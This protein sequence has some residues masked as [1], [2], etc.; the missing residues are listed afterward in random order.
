MFGKKARLQRY[1]GEQTQSGRREPFEDLKEGRTGWEGNV[2][3]IE[4]ATLLKG[5]ILK[6]L[7]HTGPFDMLTSEENIVLC[8]CVWGG[9]LI[10]SFKHSKG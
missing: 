9:L 10:F 7:H 1:V 2:W 8:V 4:G 3:L 6:R 5:L